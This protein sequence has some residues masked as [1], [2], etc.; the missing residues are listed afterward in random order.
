MRLHLQGI[1]QEY[2][3]VHSVEERH[4]NATF[5]DF[6]AISKQLSVKLH[7]LYLAQKRLWHLKIRSIFSSTRTDLAQ[8]RK[9]QKAQ[10]KIHQTCPIFAT[11]RSRCFS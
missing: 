7:V 11:Q 3:R 9:S 1:L 2:G 10:N 5:Y 8:H 6:Q 4:G